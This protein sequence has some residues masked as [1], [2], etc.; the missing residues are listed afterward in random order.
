MA[1]GH[2]ALVDEARA[3]L[4]GDSR[5]R[6]AYLFGSEA[7]GTAGAGSDVDV[8]VWTEPRFDLMQLGELAEGLQ[9]RMGKRVDLVDLWGAP[10]VLAREVTRDGIV[11]ADRDRDARLAFELEALRRY[12]DTRPLRAAQQLL[13]KERLA[14]G[15]SR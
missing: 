1:P 10:P 6:F 14:H 8:A 12:E 2:G 15:R 5:V 4:A 9:R 13:I 3:A 7:Q 11:I